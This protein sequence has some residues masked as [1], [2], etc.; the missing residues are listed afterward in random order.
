MLTINISDLHLYNL[1]RMTEK[2]INLTKYQLF[3]FIKSIKILSI[4]L[5]IIVLFSCKK[6]EIE[7]CPDNRCTNYIIDSAGRQ[8]VSDKQLDTIQYLFSKNGLTSS[9]IQFADY[10]RFDDGWKYVSQYQYVNNRK[11]FL[12]CLGFHFNASDSLTSTSGHKITSID[13][14][15]TPRLSNS[16]VRAVYIKELGKG[17]AYI[18]PDSIYNVIANGCVE[19][20]FGYLDLNIANYNQYKFTPVWF[21]KP[22]GMEYPA[23]FIDDFTGKKIV[24]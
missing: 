24:I 10:E 4:F 8:L 2:Y 13:L 22:A 1:L 15:N 9:N 6:N 5:I 21:V 14:P 16:Y 12:Y 17:D 23:Y 3:K 19:I 11:V 7:I 18:Y 20:E